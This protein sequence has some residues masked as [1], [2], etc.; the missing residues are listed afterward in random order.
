M[1][2]PEGGT[3]VPTSPAQHGV[4]TPAVVL[5]DGL[6]VR[7]QAEIDECA[8]KVTYGGIGELAGGRYQISSPIKIE[9]KQ[10]VTR[11]KPGE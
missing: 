10:D 11:T 9:Q 2:L 8:A 3:A 7:S 6:V 4:P 1:A 5:A